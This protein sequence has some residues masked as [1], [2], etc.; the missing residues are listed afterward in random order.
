MERFKPVVK[1]HSTLE[2]LSI[3][4]MSKDVFKKETRYYVFHVFQ[5]Y[6]EA[7]KVLWEN[8]SKLVCSGYLRPLISYLTC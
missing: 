6:D 7:M 3:G 2:T 5:R 8:L 1:H 4:H